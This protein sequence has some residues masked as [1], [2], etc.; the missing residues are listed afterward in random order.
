MIARKALLIAALVVGGTSAALAQSDFT[1]GTA[2]DMARSG[3]PTSYGSSAYSYAPGL[4][5]NASTSD[6]TSI[7]DDRAGAVPS[8]DNPEQQ[9][10]G[11]PEQQPYR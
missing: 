3:Y 2:G 11:N 1:T 5:S 10:S 9:P 8:T 7:P 4:D 6:P